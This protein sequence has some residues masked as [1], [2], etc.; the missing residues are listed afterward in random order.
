[1]TDKRKGR[2]QPIRLT[3]EFFPLDIHQSMF[4]KDMMIS[5][6]KYYVESWG[7]KTLS[8]H[9]ANDSWEVDFTYIPPKQLGRVKRS[10]VQNFPCLVQRKE[11]KPAVTG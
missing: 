8:T 7:P 9:K 4:I 3:S 2:K 5:L 11:V 6:P 10:S 1:M